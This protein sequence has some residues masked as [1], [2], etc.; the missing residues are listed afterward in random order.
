[1]TTPESTW[2][3]IRDASV[4]LAELVAK[5]LG[6]LPVQVLLVPD[7]TMQALARAA[8]AKDDAK[9]ALMIDYTPDDNPTR[10]AFGIITADRLDGNSR[11]TAIQ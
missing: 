11:R 7:S 1:M 2:P 5:G 8:G 9:P 10:P 3:T 6:D 4:I